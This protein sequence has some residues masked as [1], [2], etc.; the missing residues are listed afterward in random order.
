MNVNT[1]SEQKAY[2]KFINAG[3]TPEGACGLIGNLE[4]ESDGFVSN[5]V[6]YLCLQRLKENGK[7]YTHESYT[8]AVDS[9][10][11]SAEEFLHPLPGNQYGY[12]LAQWTSPTR[13]AGLYN[14]AHKKG[15]SIADED[16]QIE[17]L[18]KE[19][20]TDYSHVLKVLKSTQSIR[21]AS[22]YVLKHFEQPADTSEAVCVSRA[23][24]GQK[25]YENY[26]KGEKTMAVT[27]NDIIKIMQGW[28]GLS[29]AKGTHKSIIDT[30]NA[31]RP[32]ARG[33]KVTYSDAYCD[34]TVSAAFIK[35]GAVNLIGGT[36]CGVEEHIK[37]FKSAGIWK[38][39]GTLTPEPGWI[40]CY[41]WD[42]D[43]QPNDGYADHIGVVESVDKAQKTF[44]VIEGNMSG[45]VVGRR[46][47]NIGWGY[48]RGF[49]APKYAK[50]E[51]APA[52][53]S[54]IGNC[55]PT[56]HTFLQ[57]AQDRQVKVIQVLLRRQGYKGKDGKRLSINGKLDE[58]TAYAVEQFQRKQG[59]KDIN[60]G[61]VAAKTW[62]LLLSNAK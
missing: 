57:G 3:M 40:V 42:D 49:A 22:D 50:E 48:I 1:A 12:G 20:E 15:V 44:V 18:L 27:A 56:L 39:D 29:R 25:F 51:N 10:K 9:G 32:L 54:L 2:R 34:T 58:N 41:N 19:L 35:A 4:A 26:V 33:Y 30:Y 38:E 61:T 11:I 16:M 8:A 59:M 5:R 47:T 43:I 14:L 62:E 53:S 6:E 17:F 21:K 31:H 55:S 23:A 13:K 7:V 28:V 37:I 60:F 52:P 36:E 24:R 45:G 46:T